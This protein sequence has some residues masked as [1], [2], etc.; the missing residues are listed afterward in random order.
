[1]FFDIV[2]E[3]CSNFL[4]KE[5]DSYYKFLLLSC[6][7]GYDSMFM[8]YETYVEVLKDY[9]GEIS[10]EKYLN[11]RQRIDWSCQNLLFGALLLGKNERKKVLHYLSSK[12]H[13]PYPIL[14]N[15]LS[16]KYGLSNFLINLMT[17]MFPFKPYYFVLC[18]IYDKF[19]K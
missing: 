17:L 12:G 13:Y 6:R 2:D 5:K 8:M 14:W 10:K 9:S 3:H 15:R 4:L 11:I 7:T 18:W 19:R 1:M 16:L